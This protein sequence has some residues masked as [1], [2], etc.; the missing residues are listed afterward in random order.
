MDATARALYITAI[1]AAT[2]GSYGN[3]AITAI[4]ADQTSTFAAGFT[5]NQA[6]DVYI[7]AQNDAVK[8]GVSSPVVAAGVYGSATATPIYGAG[9][10]GGPTTTI[11]ASGSGSVASSITSITPNLANSNFL[12]CPDSYYTITSPII[13]SETQSPTVSFA[14]GYIQDFNILL[15]TG[16]QFDVTVT[17][18][19]QTFNQSVV[20]LCRSST[21][22]VTPCST[23]VSI[24]LRPLIPRTSL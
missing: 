9:A 14:Q 15:P 8:Y 20:Q 10:G 16:D 4:N 12:I 22:S 19:V 2:V 13:I 18:N 7:I 5:A 23:S 21:T 3:Y 11:P 24:I 1:G 6:Y 17:P